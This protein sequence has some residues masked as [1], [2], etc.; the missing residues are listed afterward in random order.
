M[1]LNVKERRLNLTMRPKQTLEE[2][3]EEIRTK[4]VVNLYPTVAVVLATSRSGVYAAVRSGDIE[5]IK[6]GPRRFKAISA[7]L[8][9]KLGI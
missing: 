9:Q 7:P 2:A 1:G 4:P 8:R 5:V 3:L 6:L